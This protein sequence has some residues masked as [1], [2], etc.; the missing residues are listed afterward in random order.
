M[1]ERRCKLLPRHRY[2]RVKLYIEG[3]WYGAMNEVHLLLGDVLGPD[4]T[5]EFKVSSIKPLKAVEKTHSAH[6]W[7]VSKS[8]SKIKRQGEKE[9][10][11][12]KSAYAR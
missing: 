1:A 5:E 6:Y 12:Y 9:Y 2:T 8:I 3:K 7:R 10:R 11:C 4:A